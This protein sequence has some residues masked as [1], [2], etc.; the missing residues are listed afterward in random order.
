MQLRKT[1]Y[2]HSLV[3]CDWNALEE[4][5][6]LYLETAV[7]TVG[8]NQIEAISTRFP[9]NRISI[10]KETLPWVVT[11]LL[12]LCRKNNTIDRRAKTPVCTLL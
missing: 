4:G 1:G 8:N 12:T 7:S 2:L 3:E 9:L 5:D 11:E 10:S 6:G